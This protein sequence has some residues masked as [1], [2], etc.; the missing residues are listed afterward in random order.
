MNKF[1]NC[2]PIFLSV[3]NLL[4]VLVIFI[5]TDKV[6]YQAIPEDIDK[7]MTAYLYISIVPAITAIV[8]AKQMLQK[9]IMKGLVYA[10]NIIY[11]LIYV[12]VAWIV[13]IIEP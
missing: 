3:L 2:V 12:I 10:I 11:T 4:I 7:M 6:A 8:L 13:L 1:K 5:I 9:S